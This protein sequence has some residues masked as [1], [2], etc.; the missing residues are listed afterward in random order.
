MSSSRAP[1]WMYIIAASFL[2]LFVLRIYVLSPFYPGPGPFG[3]YFDERRSLVTVARV[4]PGSIAER[5]GLRA[6]DRIVSANGLTIRRQINW[7][8]ASLT[9]EVGRPLRLDIEREGRRFDLS[10]TPERRSQ[11]VF[12]LPIVSLL[13]GA[14]LLT[15]VLAFV[16][17]FRRPNDL[18]AR[19]GAWFLATAAIFM[20]PPVPGI[21]TAWRPLPVPL[22]ALLWIAQVSG[23]VFPGIF[24]TFFA[25]FPRP[26]F[27]RRWIWWLVWAPSLATASFLPVQYALVYQQP[28]TA[29]EPFISVPISFAVLGCYVLG[30]LM[31]L[32]MN[33]R[34]LKDINERRRVRVL[35]VGAV[36]GWVAA[37]T[38]LAFIVVG[39]GRATAAFFS[40]PLPLMVLMLFP[41]FPLSFAYAILRHRVF[42]L[43]V[44]V[45]RG[46]QY[47]LARS[48]LLTAVPALGLA[49][50]IDLLVHGQQP[51]LEISRA[52]GWIYVVLGGV[53]ATAYVKRQSWL[54]SLD[55]R[56]FR[57][58]YDAQ[59][60]LRE[61]VEEIREA[62]SFERVA[63]RVVARVEAALH[64]EFAGLLVREP[65][66]PKYHNLAMA[67]SG[68]AL[69]VLPAESKL[70]S[71]VR[72]LGKPLEMPQTGSSWLG[73]QLPHEETEF[74]RRARIE[75]LVPIA[76]A[77]RT[78]LILVL[79]V[80]RSEEPYSREDQDLL[81]AIAS[82][83]ALLL[84][85]PSGAAVARTDIFEERPQCGACYD[86][87]A[88]RCVQEG[89]RLV[90]VVL[91]R[92]LEGRYRL[93]R[94]LGRGGMGTVYSAADTALERGVAVKVIREDLVGSAEAAERFRQEG[95]VAASFAHTNVVT[96]YDFGVAYGTRAF[97][98]M[99]LLEGA[100]L[101][102]ALRPQECFAPAQVLSILRDVC[103]ALEAAH[104]RQVVHR[105]LKPEN[106]FLVRSE[107]G[108]IAKVLDF[109]IAKFLSTATQQRTADTAPGA[110]LGTLRYMSP[111]QWLGQ[112]PLP[113]WDL[114]AVAVVAYEMLT[115]THPFG[116]K[117]PA[118][119][120]G[121]GSTAR[122]TPVSAHVPQ[123][124]QVW[125]EL[126]ERTLAYDPTR[127]PQS[128]E[129]L[130]S[131][132]QSALS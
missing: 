117:S 41:A 73:Q 40:T 9:F 85:K 1:W 132:L 110:L 62:R 25:T 105:D 45:R 97:L 39:G 118:E 63:P 46:L 88:T 5:A 82:S 43:G 112:Q 75:L 21:A 29:P 27:R 81:V 111:E 34:R 8:M 122:F 22:G 13:S 95:R 32:V 58:R 23:S 83:L 33:Y 129:T 51:L 17:A 92:L 108:N 50:L 106:I 90:P 94:R 14:D 123:A 89:A 60:L 113:A 119:W 38:F 74:L 24:F 68:R 47:T 84:E 107:R 78:E 67:P 72:L 71:L 102:E 44:I 31:V 56:F 18:V 93:E 52:R 7:D 4:E 130:F 49:L 126:F 36:A 64:P 2:G 69:P 80:K 103:A 15:L 120:L 59:R 124:P 121:V 114:W 10:V 19:I 57:E 70:M 101:R 53:A 37:G 131:E 76:P 77:D 96:I 11:N 42:D 79:G 48:V 127:R 98:V 28:S 109:G 35:V 3:I 6:G 12:R 55:R 26:L 65:G 115:G 54:E 30:G 66:E 61:V 125:Q 100:T 91:P 20:F 87:G 86:S 16:V 128:A 99:E 116:D 104:H